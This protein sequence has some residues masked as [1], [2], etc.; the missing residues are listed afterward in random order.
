[1]KFYELLR[2]VRFEDMV[3]TLK[4][5]CIRDRQSVGQLAYYKQAFDCLRLMKPEINDD[6][7]RVGTSDGEGDFWAR[8]LGKTIVYNE[9]LPSDDGVV[10]AHFLWNCTF[11]GFKTGAGYNPHSDEDNPYWMKSFR[12]MEKDMAFAAHL[13]LKRFHKM[14]ILERDETEAFDK[15]Y[16]PHCKMN[17]SKRMRLHRHEVMQKKYDRMAKVWETIDEIC[18]I[19]ADIKPDDLKYLYDTARI[20]NDRFESHT[21]D[22]SKR[23][24]YLLDLIDNWSKADYRS[25][26]SLVIDVL[27]DKKHPF[28]EE[29]MGKL[30]AFLDSCKLLDRAICGTLATDDF[31]EGAEIILIGSIRKSG[32]RSKK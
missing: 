5:F 28:S 27:H 13:S 15:L 31:G 12:I 25:C 3:P 7:M 16:S 1:M 24:D 32:K 8:S 6:T 14:D 17:R 29:E 21:E 4:G 26:D 20:Y 19:D 18:S 11:Y 10:A 2:R 22:P 23:I 30:N 9:G